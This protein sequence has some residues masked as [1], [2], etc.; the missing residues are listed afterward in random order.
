MWSNWHLQREFNNMNR[1]F[2]DNRLPRVRVRFG[3]IRPECGTS[4]MGFCL[5]D[6]IMLA[7]FLKKSGKCALMVL[8]HEMAHLSVPDSQNHGRKWVREMHRLH[9]AGAFNSILYGA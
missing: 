7:P 3:Y 1:K 6:R 2:F 9:D 8:L 5:P 4:F